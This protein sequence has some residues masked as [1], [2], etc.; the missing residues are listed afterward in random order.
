VVTRGNFLPAG[1]R[2]KG[3]SWKGKKKGPI[4]PLRLFSK[5]ERDS[6]RNLLR[7]RSQTRRRKPR[8][9]P[10]VLQHQEEPGHGDRCTVR[11]V[12]PYEGAGGVLFF[13]ICSHQGRFEREGSYLLSAKNRWKKEVLQKGRR[14]WSYVAVQ[15]KGRKKGDSF[16]PPRGE[17][18]GDTPPDQ[19]GRVNAEPSRKKS[20]CCLPTR[21]GERG[22]G[23]EGKPLGKKKGREP[24]LPLVVSKRGR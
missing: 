22:V 9:A 2:R 15:R 24:T 5:G 1:K 12:P 3:G 8:G 14:T 19:K 16:L 4:V 18:G 10:Y 21:G 17:R 7:A 11:K 6:Q 23:R 13:V 20:V